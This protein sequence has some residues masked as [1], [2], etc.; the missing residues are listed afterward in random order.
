MRASTADPDYPQAGTTYQY[1]YVKKQTDKYTIIESPKQSDLRPGDILVSKEGGHTAIYAGEIGVSNKAWGSYPKGA[2]LTA[3]EAAWD[4]RVP[5][6][7]PSLSYTLSLSGV[8]AARI[9]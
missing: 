1:D 3:I 2:K 7:V 4:S 9:K 6:W 5:S 8:I